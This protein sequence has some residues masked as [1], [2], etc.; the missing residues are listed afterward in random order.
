MDNCAAKHYIPVVC[1]QGST[2]GGVVVCEASGNWNAGLP[3]CICD[4]ECITLSLSA[5]C[6]RLNKQSI[7][8]R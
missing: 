1:S 6:V 8:Y 3:N 7:N 2:G 5:M 4:L